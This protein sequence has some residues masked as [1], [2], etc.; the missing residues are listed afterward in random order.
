MR[1]ELPKP[2]AALAV[3]I[4]AGLLAACT[5]APETV[6]DTYASMQDCVRDWGA[7]DLCVGQPDK[8]APRG[9]D[10]KPM[11]NTRSMHFYGPRYVAAERAQLV[12]GDESASRRLATQK[13]EKIGKLVRAQKNP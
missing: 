2:A 3:F 4:A 8:S 11:G 7:P 12:Q 6:Q 10:G 5:R 9:P 1:I 13:G